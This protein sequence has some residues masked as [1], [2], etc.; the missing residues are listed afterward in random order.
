MDYQIVS[1][2]TSNTSESGNSNLISFGVAKENCT[3]YILFLCICVWPTNWFNEDKNGQKK[4][5]DK[6]DNY[7]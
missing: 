4:Y 6:H 1:A 7:N 3:S 2:S 5:N